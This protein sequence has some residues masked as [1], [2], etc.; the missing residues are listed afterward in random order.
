MN[1]EIKTY[2]LFEKE[3]KRLAKKYKSLKD[4]FLSFSLDLKKNPIQGS[5]LGGGVHKVRMA[6][7]SKGKGK[8]GGARV[9]TLIITKSD[10]N[11]EI[12]LH[13]IYDKSDRETISDK[14]IKKVLEQNLL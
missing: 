5:D 12:G 9:I 8:R 6:I 1:Y 13:Y 11:T 4:D 7:A 2:K 14:E 10:D 3:F